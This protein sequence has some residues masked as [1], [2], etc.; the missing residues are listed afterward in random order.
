MLKI[1]KNSKGS[2]SLIEIITTSLIFTIAAFGIFSS[3]AAVQ[4]QG[5]DSDKKLMAAYAG[6]QFMET[7]KATVWSY[8]PGTYTNTTADGYTIRWTL[9]NDAAGGRSLTMDVTY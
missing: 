2:I 4:P 1:F 5:P 8:A 3:L 6:K 7:L 9:S